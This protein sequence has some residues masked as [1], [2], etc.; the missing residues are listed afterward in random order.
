MYIKAKF[1][2]CALSNSPYVSQILNE[3]TKWADFNT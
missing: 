3:P 2:V 1:S